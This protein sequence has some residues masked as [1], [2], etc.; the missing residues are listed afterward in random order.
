[1]S[2]EWDTRK[3]SLN[4]KKHGV[5]FKEASNIFFDDNR[6]EIYDAAHSEYE[7]RFAVIGMVRDVLLVIYTE[8]KDTLRIISARKATPS[9]R[10]IYYGKNR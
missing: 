5:S 8:R 1:M 6:V 4:L 3:N 9:E 2:I 10:K 7:D